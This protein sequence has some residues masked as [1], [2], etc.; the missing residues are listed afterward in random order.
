M[1]PDQ[2]SRLQDDELHLTAAGYDL[3]GGHVFGTLVNSGALAA[4]KCGGGGGG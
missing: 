2:R 3:L 4:L 1:A